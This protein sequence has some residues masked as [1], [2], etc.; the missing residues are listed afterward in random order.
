MIL[1]LQKNCR[2][3]R[4]NRL[5]LT[6]LS[7]LSVVVLMILMQRPTQGFSIVVANRVARSSSSAF[8][9]L[10]PRN[11][12]ILLSRRPY[13]SEEEEQEEERNNDKNNDPQRRQRQQRT[14]R[15]MVGD[16]VESLLTSA[17]GR[18]VQEKTA[19][20]KSA[21]DQET[22]E[23]T[24][25]RELFQS[26][27]HRAY[28]TNQ[29]VSNIKD[30]DDN[31][32]IHV[33]DDD[34]NNN[35]NY[36]YN[37]SNNKTKPNQQQSDTTPIEA[38]ATASSSSQGEEPVPQYAFPFATRYKFHPALSNVALA[39]SLW[40]SVLRPNVDTAIDATC[41]NG[42]DSV[43]IAK[44]LFVN[45][46]TTKHEQQ[47]CCYSQLLC[48]D[49]QQKACENTR[50]MLQETLSSEAGLED[51]YRT[52]VQVLHASHEVLPRP[53]NTSSVGLV[54]YNLGWLPNNNNNINNK[55]NDNTTT[56]TGDGKECVTTMETTIASL[57]DAVLLLRVG[58]MLSVVTY[59][60]TGPD[61]DTAVQLFVT[62]LALLSS[63]IQTW[64]EEIA[65]FLDKKK[66][67][68]Q[69]ENR[70]T[71]NDNDDIG[72]KIAGHVTLAMERV[73]QQGHNDQTW[74]VSNHEKLGMDRAPI[75]LT[76]TRIK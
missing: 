69:P 57:A 20:S 61:E 71:D 59:P 16:V 73:V 23:M 18:T 39:H 44:L 13:S 32:P 10:P 41:G 34:N 12:R 54:V 35:K 11:A 67:Y 21:N 5:L 63:N 49:V 29:I 60:K 6:I 3:Y 38:T 17:A 46:E 36:N 58:G 37:S 4:H 9:S 31:D 64:Q 33:D 65:S 25:I 68:Q 24:M 75:L 28:S 48:L 62:C 56:T 66:R 55:C 42:H 51:Y 76:A 43:A 15:R 70:S 53:T 1:P 19:F 2:D 52:R 14:T 72:S 47:R 27:I 7:V 50:M 22:E 45:E 40:A 74:R 30:N 26:T 8:L